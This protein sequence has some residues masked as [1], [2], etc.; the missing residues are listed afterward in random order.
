[1]YQL[2]ISKLFYLI[3]L[4]QS[5][6]NIK[7][8]TQEISQNK[9]EMNSNL[10]MKTHENKNNTT[11]QQNETEVTFKGPKKKNRVPKRIIHF[12]DGIVEE[13]STDSEEEEEIRKAAAIEEGN[14][15]QLLFPNN[16]HSLWS[17]EKY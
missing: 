6:S 1:M 2:A 7:D 16:I 3:C 12:S 4:F 13:F 15:G 9:S 17:L 10:K 8:E 11:V 14:D 5:L